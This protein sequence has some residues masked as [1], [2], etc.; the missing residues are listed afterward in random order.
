MSSGTCA[1]IVGGASALYVATRRA[2]F[3]H[4]FRITFADLPSLAVCCA[5]NT[6]ASKAGFA[7]SNSRSLPS[8]ADRKIQ[9][10]VLCCSS[11]MS[12]SSAIFPQHGNRPPR[13][14][15]SNAAWRGVLGVSQRQRPKEL[16]AAGVEFSLGPQPSQE[17]DNGCTVEPSAGAC[18]EKTMNERKIDEA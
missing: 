12:T 13:S 1:G 11:R 2:F 9:R 6:A 5:V 17:R 3:L 16:D 4:S 8:T 18:R 7:S 14:N 10:P 15:S